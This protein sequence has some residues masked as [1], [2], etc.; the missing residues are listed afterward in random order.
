MASHALNIERP[1]LSVVALVNDVLPAVR[2][3]IPKD[4]E[5]CRTAKP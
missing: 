5:V 1:G 4:A 2:G 3:E